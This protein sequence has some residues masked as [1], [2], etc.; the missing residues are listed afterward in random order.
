MVAIEGAAFAVCNEAILP[1]S[2]AGYGV[3]Q[4]RPLG[5]VDVLT[6]PLVLAALAGG[7]RPLWHPSAAP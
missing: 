3:P 4:P 2:A 1:W 5:T 6:P 7:Y